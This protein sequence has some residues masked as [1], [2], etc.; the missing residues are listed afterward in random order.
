MNKRKYN[1]Q[2]PD[3]VDK[4]TIAF[5][6]AHMVS[7]IRHAQNNFERF[8]NAIK[9]NQKMTLRIIYTP[10]DTKAFDPLDKEKPPNI[11]AI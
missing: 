5:L 11:L 9:D 8:Y 7:R 2:F 6:D 10:M 1:D 3:E 4:A